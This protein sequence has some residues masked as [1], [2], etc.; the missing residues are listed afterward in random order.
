[1]VLQ[2]IDLVVAPTGMYFLFNMYFKTRV[3][4]GNLDYSSA[5]AVAI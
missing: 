5:H 4:C 2:Y 3:N 1:M